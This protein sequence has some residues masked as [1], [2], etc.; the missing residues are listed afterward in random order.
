MENVIRYIASLVA[1]GCSAWTGFLSYMNLEFLKLWTAIDKDILEK[2][3]LALAASGN[4]W[5]ALIGF[6]LFSAI[7]G[8]FLFRSRNIEIGLSVSLI[9]VLLLASIFINILVVSVGYEMAKNMADIE[10]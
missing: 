1:L 2:G 6:S 4:Y 7:S 5:F 8:I 10:L 9:F 3:T